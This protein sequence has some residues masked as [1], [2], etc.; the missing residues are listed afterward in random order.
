MA[1]MSSLEGISKDNDNRLSTCSQSFRS[2]L[3]YLPFSTAGKWLVAALI[4]AK[5]V[6]EANNVLV[7][8]VFTVRFS[9]ME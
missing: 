2:S 7:R 9:R 1:V 3:G 6:T 8:P 5:F 4:Q